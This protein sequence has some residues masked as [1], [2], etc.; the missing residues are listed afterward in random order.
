M[1]K[2]GQEGTER[3]ESCKETVLLGVDE[4]DVLCRLKARHRHQNSIVLQEASE[5]TVISNIEILTYA[6]RFVN[7]MGRS[8]RS[9][10]EHDLLCADLS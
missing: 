7:Q 1:T 8:R 5:Y 10:C 3:T 2:L 4:V 9:H 6:G